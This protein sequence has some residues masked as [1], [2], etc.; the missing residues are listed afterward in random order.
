M[1]SYKVILSLLRVRGAIVKGNGN[2]TRFQTTVLQECSEFHM[3][4]GRV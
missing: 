1:E 2:E 4:S 3:G